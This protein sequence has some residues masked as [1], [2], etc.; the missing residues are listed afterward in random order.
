MSIPRRSP[1]IIALEIL[2]CIDQKQGKASKWDLIKILGNEA[3][4]RQWMIGFLIKD[5]FIEEIHVSRRYYYRK[6]KN[7]NLFHQLLR[8][9]NMIRALLRI[10]GKRLRRYY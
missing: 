4:F 5:K 9:G 7:G 1:D 10:S 3:Q 8:N 2:D 6:T